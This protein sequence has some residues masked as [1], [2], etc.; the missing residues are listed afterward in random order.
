MPLGLFTLSENR[1]RQE[2]LIISYSGLL[3]TCASFHGTFLLLEKDQ[4]YVT[5]G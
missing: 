1:Q 2:G 5:A 4:E 3:Y